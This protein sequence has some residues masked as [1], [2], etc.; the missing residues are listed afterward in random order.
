MKKG[1]R[2]PLPQPSKHC[3][4][5]VLELVRDCWRFDPRLR[6]GAGK[7]VEVLKKVVCE[8]NSVRAGGVI[9]LLEECE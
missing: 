3:P 4:Q 6:P 1:L 2:E 9:L 7:C 5:R 8:A